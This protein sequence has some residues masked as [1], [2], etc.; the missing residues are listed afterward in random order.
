MPQYCNFTRHSIL[1]L[2]LYWMYG[3]DN[4]VAIRQ[5]FG[6]SNASFFKEE[7]FFCYLEYRSSKVSLLLNTYWTTRQHVPEHEFEDPIYKTIYIYIHVYN[8]PNIKCQI[9]IRGQRYGTL[10]VEEC[11]TLY[12]LFL[13][14]ERD[15]TADYRK[16]FE[17]TKN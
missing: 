12:R 11:S 14:V 6:K 13:A 4:A 15:L 16:H 9:S 17:K 3:R 10:P 8:F 1:R 7:D 2:S 5:H